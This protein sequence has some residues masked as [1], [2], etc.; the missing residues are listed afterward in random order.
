MPNGLCKTKS[1]QFENAMALC[2]CCVAFVNAKA[3]QRHRNDEFSLSN[4]N[5]NTSVLNWFNSHVLFDVNATNRNAGGRS[6]ALHWKKYK[7]TGG[8]SAFAPQSRPR[9]HSVLSLVK[10]ASSL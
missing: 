3:F 9:L 7:Q 2:N 6:L 10:A 5:S 4:G 1:N 8:D